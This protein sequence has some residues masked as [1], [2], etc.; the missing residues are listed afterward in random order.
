MASDNP[1]D[2]TEKLPDG[3][4]GQNVPEDYYL[5]SCGLAD[6]DRALFNLFDK[7]I[8]FT[9]SSKQSSR[10][11]PVI[12]AGAEKFAM[13][14]NQ[15][16]RDENGAFVLPMISIARTGIDQSENMGGLGRGIGQDSGDLVIKTRLSSDDRK[17]QAIKNKLNLKNQ[18][19]VT[20]PVHETQREVIE[21]GIARR[22]V[23]TRRAVGDNRNDKRQ[24]DMLRGNLTDNIIEII[25]VPFPEFFS[26]KYE[27]VFWTQYQQQMNELLEQMISSYHAQGN[28]FR[29]DTEKGYWFVAFVD[30]AL[31]AN[32]NFEDYAEDERIIK[33]SF[34]ITTT[35]YLVAPQ[36]NG[37]RSPLRVFCSAPMIEFGVS[38][39]S[40][41]I[42]GPRSNGAGSGDVNKFI[43][44]DVKELDKGG[45]DVVGRNHSPYGKVELI[46]NPFTGKRE[47]KFLRVKSRN[48]RKGETVLGIAPIIKDIE[49]I[50]N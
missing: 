50:T 23:G 9:I 36:H 26:V 18:T 28:Q 43:L 17:Y 15:P 35:G 7:K 40:P 14:K 3:Y 12:F 11:V 47:R 42:T 5:P 48:Q 41:G 37:Q 46:E 2:V 20:A 22:T 19:N 45:N 29:I 31:T 27:V 1:Y 39:A 38:T 4:E 44:S 24:G 34:S 21:D 49:D 16:A 10:A 32:D 25:T 30:D 13:V 6:I 33:Y 8:G